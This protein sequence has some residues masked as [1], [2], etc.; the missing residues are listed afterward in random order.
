[1][2]ENLFNAAPVPFG[3][4]T[5]DARVIVDELTRGAKVY[6]SKLPLPDRLILDTVLSRYQWRRFFGAQP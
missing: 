1:V 5:G 6:G 3:E 2:N 4:Y